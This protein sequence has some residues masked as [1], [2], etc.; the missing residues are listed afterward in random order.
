MFVLDMTIKK[1]RSETNELSARLLFM[2]VRWTKNLTSFA[3]L[4]FRDQVSIWYISDIFIHV[5]KYDIY[6]SG[7]FTWRELVR[8]LCIVHFSMEFHI[9]RFDHVQPRWIR[10]FASRNHDFTESHV[11]SVSTIQS[12]ACQSSWIRMSQSRRSVQS[13]SVF[14]IK[15]GF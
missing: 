15:T 7:N 3:S 5:L 13:R 8:N 2:A 12:H 4:P 6:Y 1:K 10:S 11:K 14:S 9:R